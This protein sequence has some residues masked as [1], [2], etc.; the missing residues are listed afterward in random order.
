MY[1]FTSIWETMII[2]YITKHG[3]KT[4]KHTQHRDYNGAFRYIFAIIASMWVLRKLDMQSTI[5]YQI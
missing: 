5:N 4:K 1:R 3:K 2:H